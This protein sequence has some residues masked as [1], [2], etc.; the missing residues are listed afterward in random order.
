MASGIAERLYVQQPFAQ[1]LRGAR[2][3]LAARLASQ[4][5]ITIGGRLERNQLT[6]RLSKG[7]SVQAAFKTAR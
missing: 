1:E 6:G 7:F 4:A 3:E 5:T 2:L